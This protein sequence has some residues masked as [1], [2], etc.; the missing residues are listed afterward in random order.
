MASKRQK[1]PTGRFTP[2]GNVS[3]WKTI[4]AWFVGGWK[5]APLLVLHGPCGTGKTTGV[6]MIAELCQYAVVEINGSV[7]RND[8]KMNDCV[9]EISNKSFND[10]RSVLILDD[11]QTAEASAV[12]EL[13]ALYG[14]QQG[15]GVRRALPPTVCICHDY[16]DPIMR[17]LFSIV[18]ASD[19]VELLPVPVDAMLRSIHS[20]LPAPVDDVT[21]ESRQR[22]SLEM[23]QIREIAND[24]GGDIRQLVTRVCV[25]G[26]VSFVKDDLGVDS[27]NRAR[28]L[29]SSAKNSDLRQRLLQADEFMSTAMLFH[30]YSAHKH[31]RTVP[32]I[33]DFFS[34]A[35]TQKQFGQFYNEAAFLIAN[36]ILPHNA[37]S[38]SE[39]TKLSFPTDYIKNERR[40]HRSSKIDVDMLDVLGSRFTRQK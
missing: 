3:S 17:P 39:K 32:E 33:A 18:A 40:R 27:W 24:V 22:T 16:W 9:R 12:A 4:W 38:S 6:H 23:Q 13:V 19:S 28:T 25:G 1:M 15:V 8:A 10:L 5:R 35:D 34:I 30:N 37:A 14:Q 26:G 21:K 20:I 11:M 31:T 7:Y 2:I 36:C 29:M